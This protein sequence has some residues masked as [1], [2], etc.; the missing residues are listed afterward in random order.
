M[1]RR[2]KVSRNVNPRRGLCVL[3]LI[4]SSVFSVPQKFFNNLHPLPNPRND[5]D[6]LSFAGLL[7]PDDAFAAWQQRALKCRE[8]GL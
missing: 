2:F 3:V 8:A 5:N 6:E 7:G 4:I 1:L